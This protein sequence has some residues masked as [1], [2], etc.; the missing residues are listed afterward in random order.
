MRIP[1]TNNNSRVLVLA[2]N[3]GFTVL[4]QLNPFRCRYAST[5]VY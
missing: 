1:L 4:A 2:P 3:T 5:L